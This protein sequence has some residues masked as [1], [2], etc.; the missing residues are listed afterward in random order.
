MSLNEQ[1]ETKTVKFAEDTNDSPTVP[2]S[3]AFP[4]M[5]VHAWHDLSVGTSECFN[6]LIEIPKGSKIKYQ[7]DTKYGLL[8]VSHILS[9]SLTYPANYGFIPQTLGEDNDPIDVLVFMQSSCHPMSMMACR[10]IGVLPLIDNGVTEYKVI[11]VHDGDPE[12]RTVTELSHLRPHVLN[13]IKIFY[14]DYKKL[15]KSAPKVE[16]KDVLPKEDALKII[17]EGMERYKDY[18]RKQ[19]KSLTCHRY[20]S[21]QNLF[22]KGAG[23]L[24][25]FDEDEE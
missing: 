2:T 11:A 10:P 20:G 14:E 24:A 12:Y 5:I 18:V 9:S 19:K 16:V 4:H 8:K 6:A 17:E 22:K 21:Y 1:P 3:V 13:E 15:D 25:A 7:Y 23:D